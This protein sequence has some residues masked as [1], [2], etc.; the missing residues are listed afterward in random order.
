VTATSVLLAA[1]DPVT[2][3]GAHRAAVR[4][5]S[6]PPYREAQPSLPVR[7]LRWVVELVVKLLDAV[8]GVPGGRGGVALLALVL[9]GVVAVV[10]TRLGPLARGRTGAVEPVG[11]A[12]LTP[13]GHRA[14]AEQAAREQRWADAVR[15]R[16]RALAR[17]LEERGVL[18]ARPGR[19]ADEVARDGGRALPERAEDLR[20]AAA[21]FDEVWYGGRLADA[22]SYGVLVEVDDRLCAVGRR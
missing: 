13:G 5:L 6:R 19:T 22:G 10:V 9:L 16:M 12:R 18:D 20:R 11:A 7:A 3:D 1:A 4:E 2:R 14:A 21:V 8:P 17:E 15:E